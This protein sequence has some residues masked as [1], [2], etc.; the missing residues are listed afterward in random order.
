[1]AV[2]YRL[3]PVTAFLVRDLG[4]VKLRYFSLPNLLAG[5]ELVQEFFQQDVRPAALAA[6]LQ[7]LLEDPAGNGAMRRRF[8]EIHQLLRRDAAA[9]AAR[10]VLELAAPRMAA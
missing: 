4:L 2:A 1:M 7:Q 3:A 5:E 9:R 6:S 8:Q 10:V